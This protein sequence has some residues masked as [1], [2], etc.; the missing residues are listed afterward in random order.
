MSWQLRCVLESFPGSLRKQPSCWWRGLSELSADAGLRR[1]G[2]RK[3]QALRGGCRGEGPGVRTRGRRSEDAGTQW[4]SYLPAHGLPTRPVLRSSSLGR[5]RACGFP[6]RAALFAIFRASLYSFSI[7][8]FF[9]LF[10]TF[11]LPCFLSPWRLFFFLSSLDYSQV[12]YTAIAFTFKM[13]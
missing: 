6:L 12:T 1:R 13:D 11:I 9:F 7:P 10:L 3:L 4:A 5:A 2:S 8:S